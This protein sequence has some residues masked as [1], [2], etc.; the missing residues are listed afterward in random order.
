MQHT[1][2]DFV[3]FLATRLS[4]LAIAVAGV[5]IFV[6]DA[7]HDTISDSQAMAA[8]KAELASRLRKSPDG[9][10]VHQR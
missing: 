1:R 3:W 7:E 8:H 2:S 5:A 10:P 6:S 4:A 9:Q